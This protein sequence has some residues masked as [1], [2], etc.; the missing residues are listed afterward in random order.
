MNVEALARIEDWTDLSCSLLFSRHNFWAAYL[1]H[2]HEYR[3]D[4]AFSVSST[5][6]KM[7]V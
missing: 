7:Q 6:W 3:C 4:G 1:C 5:F 2:Q